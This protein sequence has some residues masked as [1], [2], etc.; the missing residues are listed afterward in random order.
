MLVGFPLKANYFNAPVTFYFL[1]QTYYISFNDLGKHSSYPVRASVNF[2]ASTCMGG[3]TWEGWWSASKGSFI[4]AWSF[5]RK[6][7]FL[8]W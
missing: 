4:G 5:G 7:S 8:P 1:G 6:D 2:E 3:E